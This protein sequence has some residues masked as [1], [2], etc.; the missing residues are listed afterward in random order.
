MRKVQ[1][2]I[3]Q[4]AKHFDA[5]YSLDSEDVDHTLESL[6]LGVSIHTI[7]EVL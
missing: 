1:E 7:E 3:D 5:E 4:E 2:T 6:D